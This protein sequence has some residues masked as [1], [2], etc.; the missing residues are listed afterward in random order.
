[1]DDALPIVGYVLK[2]LTDEQRLAIFQSV[3]RSPSAKIAVVSTNA[4]ALIG[5]LVP[6]SVALDGLRP[7]PQDIVATL[8]ELRDVMF[9]SSGD[10]LLLVNPRLRMVVGVL[11]P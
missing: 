6:S 11:G 4:D 2:H 1:V 8:P 10:K 7:L 9:T 5:A 3:H